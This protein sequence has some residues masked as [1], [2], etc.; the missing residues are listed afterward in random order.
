M[1]RLPVATVLR[2]PQPDFTTNVE[3][4]ILAGGAHHT[5]FSYDLTVEQMADWAEQTGIE[6]LIID[7]HTSLRQVKQHLLPGQDFYR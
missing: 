1:P 5:A 2:M 6:A 7:R 4:W 3:A